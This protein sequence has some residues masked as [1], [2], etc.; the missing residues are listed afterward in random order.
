MRLKFTNFLNRQKTSLEKFLKLNGIVSY[1]QLCLHLKSIG[2]SAPDRKEVDHAFQDKAEEQ[3]KDV[4]ER[5][6]NKRPTKVIKKNSDR[7]STRRSATK[8]A[9][10][11]SPR[12]SRGRPKK[13]DTV[14]PILKTSG[15]SGS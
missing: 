14:V 8:R 15:S 1:E 9:K 4:E 3:T 10:S 7:N 12:R 11:T 2:V 5:Q 13:S 6:P